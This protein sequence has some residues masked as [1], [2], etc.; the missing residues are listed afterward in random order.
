M[1]M[2]IKYVLPENVSAGTKAIWLGRILSGLAIA[3]FIMDGVMKLIQ[4]Q[5]VIDA[6]RQ[7][8][9]PVDPMTLTALGL[10]LLACTALYAFPR[11]AV[12][13]AILLT[14]YLGGAV[15]SHARHGDPLFTH[16]FFAVYLGLFVW[17][18]LWFRDARIRSLIPF[19]MSQFGTDGTG[20]RAAVLIQG[21]L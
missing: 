5:V 21:G 9:W 4:P 17:G 20:S 2:A 19:G 10:I 3:F 13:G 8:G 18:G 7:I 16:D 14:G 15:A 11:T 6:T 12:L 1:N